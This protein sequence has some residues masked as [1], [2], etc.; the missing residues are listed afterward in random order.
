MVDIN[1]TMPLLDLPT[2]AAG[3]MAG[4]NVEL[5]IGDELFTREQMI[6][7]AK[8][9]VT[10]D[11]E[12]INR[13]ADERAVMR[14]PEVPVVLPGAWEE[15]EQGLLTQERDDGA[16][17]IDA[18]FMGDTV[19]FT[20]KAAC[21]LGGF[22]TAWQQ[23]ASATVAVNDKGALEQAI[24]DMEQALAARFGAPSPT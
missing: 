15:V 2:P 19:R 22:M 14:R 20:A 5:K 16:A 3:Y 13:E 4:C 23:L 12:S 8:A 7:F 6:R 10:A 1:A 9:C 11:R 21:V 18:C 17:R 24:A